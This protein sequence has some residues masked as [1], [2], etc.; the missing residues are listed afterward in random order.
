MT[1]SNT[2]F[3]CSFTSY[4][5]DF[6]NFRSTAF[7]GSLCISLFLRHLLRLLR[8]GFRGDNNNLS[9]FRSQSFLKQFVFLFLFRC[10]LGHIPFSSPFPGTSFTNPRISVNRFVSSF[11][12]DKA[13][14]TLTNKIIAPYAL[15]TISKRRHFP[16]PT[17]TFDGCPIRGF[18]RP[19]NDR[20]KKIK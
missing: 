7:I 8:Q 9:F 12:V 3:L 1:T 18:G 16:A 15:V 10:I 11:T 17:G 5:H 4:S 2:T 6:D 19:W 20:Q 13:F 14:V